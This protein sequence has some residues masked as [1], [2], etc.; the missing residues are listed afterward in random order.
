MKIPRKVL[1]DPRKSDKKFYGVGD[2]DPRKG[3]KNIGFLE[4]SAVE[5]PRIISK[6]GKRRNFLYGGKQLFYVGGGVVTAYSGAHC[7]VF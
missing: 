2:K 6:N 1:I 3:D 7:A 5:F 4:I